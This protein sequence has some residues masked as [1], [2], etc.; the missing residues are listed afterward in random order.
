[1]GTGTGELVTTDESAVVTES[2]FDAIVMKD[3]QS[4][5]CLSDST[6]TNEGDGCEVFGQTDDPLNQ[7][8]TSETGPRR[9]GR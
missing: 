5:G 4:D 1:M 2:L 9:R 6:S 3:S 7:L 8:V